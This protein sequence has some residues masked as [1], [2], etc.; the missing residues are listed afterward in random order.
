[1]VN[2]S[3]GVIVFFVLI[4]CMKSIIFVIFKNYFYGGEEEMWVF[5]C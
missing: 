3:C 1:M 2:V 4:V 5:G